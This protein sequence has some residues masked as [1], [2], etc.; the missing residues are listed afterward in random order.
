MTPAPPDEAQQGDTSGPPPLQPLHVDTPRVVQIGTALWV[1]ALVLS[2][3]VP[4]LHRGSHSWWPWAAVTGVL[5]GVF[6]LVYLHRG[7][8]NAAGQ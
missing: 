4:G 1:V 2:L 5:L 8:G 6:G 7:R 3:A